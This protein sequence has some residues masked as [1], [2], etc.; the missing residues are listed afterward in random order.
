MVGLICD[1]DRLKRLFS[2][3]FGEKVEDIKQLP[4]SG[5][6]RVYY[7]LSSPNKVAMGAFNGD[8]AE[9]EAFFSFTATFSSLQINVPEIYAVAPDRKHYLLSDLGDE[10]LCARIEKQQ[11]SKTKSSL[12]LVKESLPVLI[13]MQVEGAKQIDFT[14]C[15]PRSSFDKQSVM[16]DL[17]YFKYC[18]LKISNLP[19]SEQ[20]LEDDFITLSDYLLT[21]PG[22]FF[23]H[24]DFQT[25]NIMVKDNAPWIIDYQGGRRGPLPYDLASILF[26][27]KTRLN[28]LQREVLLEYYLTHLQL[29]FPVQKEE[30][31]K[32]YYA[33]VLIR[34]LQALGAYGYRGLIQGKPNFKVSIPT[35]ISNVNSLF[36]ENKIPI[37]LVE[38]RRIF[39]ELQTANL[40]SQFIPEKDLLTVRITSFSYKNGIPAD[41]SENGGG[42]V[43]DCRGLPNPGRFQEYRHLTGLDNEVISYLENYQQVKDFQDNVRNMVEI[44]VKEYI[45]RGFSHLC[46]NFG[47]TGGQH[48]SVYNAQKFNQ[49]IGNNFPVKTVLIHTEIEKKKNEQ[50]KM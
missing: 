1:V 46:V 47:C 6:D 11:K 48:R 44:S 13:K 22:E 8:V 28:N 37:E 38:I 2:D 24:R 26:S 4:L 42:F 50:K 12:C 33:F 35:A 16:W 7:R 19:F 23:M 17:N 3:F 20:G 14:K 29:F 32:Q 49:W 25:R 36:E 27:P 21:V 41:P 9:N 30:F 43:F 40:F 34:I 18:F 5:S 10:T 39:S 31:I 15:Y 45:E